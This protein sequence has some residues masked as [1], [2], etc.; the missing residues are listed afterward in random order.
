MTRLLILLIGLLAGSVR[1]SI[2]GFSGF[3]SIS[4]S[5]IHPSGPGGAVL[6]V[7]GPTL[8]PPGHSTVPP[9]GGTGAHCALAVTAA[10][11]QSSLVDHTRNVLL[12]QSGPSHIGGG[13]CITYEAVSAAFEQ[14]A[15]RYQLQP[16]ADYSDVEQLGLLGEALTEVAA[17]LAHTY[18]LP[19]EAILH[20]LPLIDTYQTSIAAFCPAH[21]SA[22]LQCEVSRYR[23]IDG[24]CN[25]LDNPTWGAARTTFRRLL[26]PHYIDGVSAPKDVLAGLPL[27]SPRRVSGTLHNDQGRHDHAVTVMLVAWGQMIDHDMTFTAEVKPKEIGRNGRP[28]MP[29]CCNDPRH[30]DNPLCYPIVIPAEDEF[31]GLYGQRCMNL[32]RSLAGVHNHC[33]LGPR[34]PIN[35]VTSYLDASFVY[36]SD[37]ETARRMRT[38]QGGLL[39]TLPVFRE[40]GLKDLLPPNLHAPD[41]GC[42]RPSNDIFCFDAGDNRVN[43][44]LVLATIQ[45][46]FVRDHNRIA[47]ELSLINPHWDDQTL[48]QETKMIMAALC[49]HITYNEFLPMVLG[50]E[51]MERE[52]LIL[53]K[54]YKYDPTLEGSTALSFATATFRF[55]HSLL[56]AVV[57]RWSVSRKYIGSR[58]LS[59]LLRQP[60][61]MYRGGFIDQY[62]MGLIN[63]VAQAM[64]NLVTQEVTNHLFQMPE[65]RFGMD[66]AAINMQRGREHGIPGYNDYRE[67][68]GLPRI[69]DFSQLHDLMVNDTALGYRAIYSHPDHIDLWSGAISERPLAGSMVGPTLGCLIGE[70]FR[71]LRYGDR[72]WYENHG[73]PSAFTPEQIGEIKKMKL[74]SIICDN[75]DHIDYIQPYVMVL[76]DPEINPLVPCATLPRLDLSLWRDLGAAGHGEL[77]RKKK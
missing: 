18:N 70:Q 24:T 29:D 9:P 6:P 45:T 25:N 38:Y 73:F 52:S 57:E 42:I 19:R 34:D 33:K 15:A 72:F 36:G 20:G 7:T 68:C 5:V 59:E 2:D 3:S 49:Q 22:G 8:V 1:A 77:L 56:P 62:V 11:G 51:V 12:G 66:L 48:Y 54:G 76:S 40:L 30:A 41:E 32:I 47:T 69:T 27:P 53:G 55:G 26:A 17:S 14:A 61:D 75:S 31:Y 13:T 37:E 10:G 21:L 35:T 71:T 28:K 16:Q 46:Y 39:K 23:T 63:Q 58:R 60:Y 65:N 44:Q 50:R 43:E 74:S 4:S 67:Y 64:D